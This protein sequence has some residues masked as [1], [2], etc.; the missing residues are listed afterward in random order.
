MLTGRDYS[1]ETDVRWRGLAGTGRKGLRSNNPGSWYPILNKSDFS[2][3]SIGDAIG[4]DVDDSNVKA[5]P[6][7]IAVWPPTKDG[8]QFSW[9]TV[10]ET[11][12]SIHAKGGFKTGRINPKKGSY[13]FYYLSTG[14]FEK[15]AKGEIV[16][17]GR[18]PANELIIEFVEG[19]KSAGR[20][21]RRP[22]RRLLGRREGQTPRPGRLR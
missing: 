5:P 8:H 17:V 18:G 16:V 13:P 4:K 14:A 22:A 1:S 21:Y 11:L 3:H 7:T 20:L 2:I 15:I 12:R 19:S 10:P 9:S 6:G